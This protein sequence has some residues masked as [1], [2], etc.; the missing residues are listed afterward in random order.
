[1]LAIGMIFFAGSSLVSPLL[2]GRH[3]S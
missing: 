1:V 3:F 2:G